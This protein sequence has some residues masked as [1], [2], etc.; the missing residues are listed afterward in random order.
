MVGKDRSP[1]S[2]P[3]RGVCLHE[4][5]TTHEHKAAVL[6]YEYGFYSE[7]EYIATASLKPRRLLIGWRHALGRGDQARSGQGDHHI[8]YSTRE[9]SCRIHHLW[10]FLDDASMVELLA[11]GEG[12][13]LFALK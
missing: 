8:F 13:A 11:K 6:E 9:G 7:R 1:I 3:C 2:P 5:R 10:K 4:S 12:V